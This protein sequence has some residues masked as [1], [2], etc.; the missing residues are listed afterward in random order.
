MELAAGAGLLVDMTGEA[1][2]KSPK[3]LPKLL[4]KLLLD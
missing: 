1:D 2:E 3:S 4:P